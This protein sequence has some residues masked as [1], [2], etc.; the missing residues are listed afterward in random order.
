M[1]GSS[2]GHKD[3]TRTANTLRKNS[4]DAENILWS[5]LRAKQCQG[6]KFR[7]QAPIGRYVVDFVCHA[8]KLV[9]EVDG[10][11]HAV[12]TMR[13]QRREA[14]L[15]AQGYSVLRFWNNDVL[16]NIEGVLESIRQKVLFLP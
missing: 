11:Q 1:K 2:M 4:T 15:A 14:W 5:H 9:I 16:E 6:F 3:L 13:D 12:D 10:G 8:K 7:R